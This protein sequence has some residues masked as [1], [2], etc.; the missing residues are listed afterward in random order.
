MKPTKKPGRRA[1]L[2]LTV[3]GKQ[4]HEALRASFA[5]HEQLWLP[6]RD[7]IQNTRISV[8]ALMYDAGRALVE[9]L[10]MVSA[11]EVAG[12][13]PA[14]RA[15]GDV[16]WHGSQPGRIVMDERKLRVQ[17][18]RLRDKRGK[19]VP[20]PAYTQLRDDEQLT[21]RMY[22][23]MVSGVSTR[24]Y[25]EALP[26]MA[27]TIGIS[28]SSV[29]R[30]FVKASKKKLD[31]LMERRFEDHDILAI[32]LDGIIVDGCHILTAIGVESDAQ[33]H[34]MGLASGS[35]ENAEVV[36]DLLNSLIERGLATDRDYLFVID[37]SK[38]LRSAIQA[39][40]GELAHVQRCRTHKIR[41]VTER[42]AKQTRQQVASVMRAAYKL[43]ADDG[44][45]RLKAQ[46]AW[47][48]TDHPDAAASLLEGL[49]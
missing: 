1:K 49:E 29:S 46:A 36:K 48:K 27:H 15:A 6:M 35:S 17:R 33:K 47:L 34:L 9:Q 37:G 42:L 11:R 45:A 32:Y 38:A 23:I 5:E 10:L 2:P 12:D 44:L 21:Q 8:D 3:A 18:P 19:E 28:K 30:Q 22:D 7:L 41:N 20:I 26:E 43:P 39:V 13:K 31:G 16:R 40:F 25:D 24:K 14:G 4:E